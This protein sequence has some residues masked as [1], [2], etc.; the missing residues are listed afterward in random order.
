[1]V[2]TRR[3]KAVVSTEFIDDSDE[4][5]GN[6]TYEEEGLLTKLYPSSSDEED[7]EDNDNDEEE[8]EVV[9]SEPEIVE[10]PST[11]RKCGRPRKITATPTPSNGKKR[12]INEVTASDSEAS[13]VASPKKP[14]VAPST[15][16]NP[17]ATPSKNTPAKAKVANKTKTPTKAKTTLAVSNKATSPSKVASTK[18]SEVTASNND[19]EPESVVSDDDPSESGHDSPTPTGKKNKGRQVIFDTSV[20]KTKVSIEK[21]KKKKTAPDVFDKDEVMSD[22][23]K[24]DDG[25]PKLSKCGVAASDLVDPLLKE[26]YKKLTKLPR[27]VI[28]KYNASSYILLEPY[29]SSG[30]KFIS[31]KDNN[32]QE[33]DDGNGMILFSSIGGVY[34]NINLKYIKGLVVFE[35]DYTSNIV[36]LSRIDPS[37]LI[38]KKTSGQTK[39]GPLVFIRDRK[40]PALCVTLGII[41]DDQ[42]ISPRQRGDKEVKFV[43]AKLLAY[44]YERMVAV[45][46]MTFKRES[47]RVQ[48]ADST[49]TFATR[50]ADLRS[51]YA[52]HLCKHGAL[53]G[54][55]KLNKHG[56]T[57]HRLAKQHQRFQNQ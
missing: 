36:N 6:E 27:Q 34:P 40:T 53:F 16:K 18:K 52:F 38:A 41:V 35:K 2:S 12:T 10:V 21:L 46:C 4:S 45:L 14:R 22:G 30:L 23:D 3:K 29:K 55:H 37:L 50:A 20:L 54:K 15:T 5:D 49:L 24:T 13:F 19:N 47:V 32:D 17:P 42:L 31:W 26:T 8:E 33:D 7:G 25:Y 57:K 28:N 56:L 43:T 44:E 11:P 51:A 9:M 48:L 39:G 1:M